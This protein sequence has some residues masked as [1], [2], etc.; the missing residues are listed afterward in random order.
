MS[1]KQTITPSQISSSNAD[2]IGSMR[3]NSQ[4]PDSKSVS[5]PQL[6]SISKTANDIRPPP[7]SPRKTQNNERDFENTL[8]KNHQTKG[9]PESDATIC[10][11]S[12][13]RM[14]IDPTLSMLKSRNPFREMILQPI[15]DVKNALLL[16]NKESNPITLAQPGNTESDPTASIEFE[17]DLGGLSIHERMKRL[18]MLGVQ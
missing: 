12:M 7:K 3:F 17:E 1:S 14:P 15:V 13:D 8:S 2:S 16:Q 10:E 18:K 4:E 6:A 11:A 9:I 5:E